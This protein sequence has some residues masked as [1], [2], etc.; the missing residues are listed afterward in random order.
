MSNSIKISVLTVCL[1]AA[2]TIEN[3]LKSILSQTYSNIELVVVDGASSDGTVDILKKYAN[4]IACLISEPDTGIYSAMNKAIGK[5]TGDYL[6]FMNAN[7]SFY[8]DNVVQIVVDQIEKNPKAEFFYGD[9]NYIDINRQSSHIVSYGKYNIK[10]N[11]FF[12]SNNV[13]H[14]VIFYKKN[15]FVKFGNYDET[16]KILADWDFNTRSLKGTDIV[17][18]YIPLVIANFQLG[19]LS[20]KENSPN[21][22]YFEKELLEKKYYPK[23]I[24]IKRILK[25]VFLRCK[26]C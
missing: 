23:K 19:G 9:A 20:M 16:Y 7:D 11:D 14:Q 26:Y 22:W 10:K 4:K 17:V 5:A 24:N 8:N 6:I 18:Q 1:N 3:T 15:L 12:Y 21:R 25:K 13:N 2:E